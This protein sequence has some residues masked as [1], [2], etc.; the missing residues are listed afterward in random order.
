MNRTLALAPGASARLAKLDGSVF[1]VQC[2]S[3]SFELYLLPQEMGVRLMG[4]CEHP[5]T[6]AVR[7]SA[8]DFTELASASDPAATLINGALEI[9]G[10]SAP[11]IELQQILGDLDVDWEAPL[12]DAFGDVPGHQ[13]A[14]GLR[15][16]FGW[17]QRAGESLRRQLSE[18]ILEEARLSPP[19]LQ[20]EDFYS[21]VQA[22]GLD[23]ERLESRITRL[24]QRLDRLRDS[25]QS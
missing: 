12:V 13:L 3:P 6:T 25:Q 5:I 9:D 21:D 7:G 11:L 15:G 23:V 4:V 20:L 2:T 8:A 18:F 16:A 1:C 14:A 24:K 19:R 10:D 17:G 22:L